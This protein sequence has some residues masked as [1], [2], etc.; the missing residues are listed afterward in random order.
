MYH[1]FMDLDFWWP[2]PRGL[3]RLSIQVES[4]ESTWIVRIN[5]SLWP[6]FKNEEVSC[7]I[8]SRILTSS[9]LYR[10]VE[11]VVDSSR[12]DQI[13]TNRFPCCKSS[14]DV[15]CESSQIVK[16]PRRIDL[17]WMYWTWMTT[18]SQSLLIMLWS[19]AFVL[20]ATAWEYFRNYYVN[21]SFG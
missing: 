8:I 13:N 1:Y 11:N 21:L 5:W 18:I 3:K 9:G 14:W 7:I 16:C 2:V 10:V 4:I 19:L 17:V 20:I 15:T 12:F 6:R